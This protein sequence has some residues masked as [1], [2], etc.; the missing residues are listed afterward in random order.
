M[1]D[2]AG[3]STIRPNPY[4]GPRAFQFGETMYGRDQEIAELLDVLIAKRIVLLYSPSGAGKSSLIE[5]GLRAELTARDFRVFPTIRVGAEPPDELNGRDVRNRY[6]LSTIL[7]L[8][9]GRP[10]DRQRPFAEL[11]SVDLDSYLEDLCRDEE[12]VS[13]PCFVFDQFEELFT[14]DPTDIDAKRAFVTELGVALRNPGRWVLFAMR[15]D[16]IAQLDPY[17]QRVPNR[18]ATR[19]RLDLLEPTAAKLAARRPAADLGVAFSEDAADRLVSD[20]RRV[21][22]QRGAVAGYEPGPYVEP[23]QLQVVCRQLWSRL[24]PAA[25]A[26][27]VDDVVALGNVDDALANFYVDEVVA[28]AARTG[29]SEREIRTWFDQSLISP[30][31]FRTQTLDGPGAAGEA[32]LRE[33]ENAHLIRADRRRGTEWYELSHDRLVAPVQTSNARWREEHLNPLQREA[34]TWDARS[35]PAGLLITGEVLTEAEQWAEAHEAELL[36]IDREYLEASR[37]EQRRLDLEH[38]VHR[39]NRALTAVAVVVSVLALAALVYTNNQ[40]ASANRARA[41]AVKA[42][43]DRDQL[44]ASSLWLAAG[45]QTADA[46]IQALAWLEAFEHNPGNQSPDMA[47]KLMTAQHYLA[48]DRLYAGTVRTIDPTGA[49]VAFAGDDGRVRVVDVAT[50]AEQPG[51]ALSDGQ[52]VDALAYGAIGEVLGVGRRGAV[53]LWEGDG[54]AGELTSPGL[55]EHSSIAGLSIAGGAGGLVAAVAVDESSADGSGRLLVWDAGKAIDPPDGTSSGVTRAVVAGNRLAVLVTDP[56]D[57]AAGILQVWQRTPTGWLEQPLVPPGAQPPAV[58]LGGALAL[59]ADGRFVAAGTVSGLQVYPTF[60]PAAAPPSQPADDPDRR[61]ANVIGASFLTAGGDAVRAV[62]TS[63]RVYDWRLQPDKSWEGTPRATLP[64]SGDVQMD[65][66]GGRAVAGSGDTFTVA[67]TVTGDRLLGQFAASAGSISGGRAVVLQRSGAVD[68]QASPQAPWTRGTPSGA[69]GLAL[70]PD[71][72]RRALL[73]ASGSS[74]QVSANGGTTIDQPLCAELSG[75]E[76]AAAPSDAGGIAVAIADNGAVVAS[77]DRPGA[78]TWC[79]ALPGRSPFPGFSLQDE[80]YH[81]VGISA[82][83]SHFAVGTELG[84]GGTADLYDADGKLLALWPLPSPVT[85]VT[86]AA[87][88]AG[89]PQVVAGDAQGNIVAFQPE[90]TADF[91]V[92][93]RCSAAL[94]TTE[95]VVAMSATAG[96]FGALL[97]A[98][99]TRRGVYV[100]EVAAGGDSCHLMGGFDVMRD[101]G[102]V[103]ALSLDERGQVTTL[104]SDFNVYSFDPLAPPAKVAEVVSGLWDAHGTS[105]Y[106]N[107]DALPKTARC[108]RP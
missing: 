80:R 88:E 106:L 18:L 36:P 32:V 76:G 85:A 69:V 16:F 89:Q 64:P 6:V 54:K 30:D 40:R 63:G 51:P 2:P 26:I 68:D 108:P 10:R 34:Q 9:E 21:R 86:F 24:A 65:G 57:A 12:S 105:R 3:A 8:E 92:T 81:A 78:S 42:L 1:T 103:L 38:K 37:A 27:T 43:A 23:V 19:Y 53:S 45:A 74:V 4:V 39:R 60:D 13:D 73:S 33:L 62:D 47:R 107:C 11:A 67:D 95:P 79:L 97:I 48:H 52:P 29:V 87:G 84:G 5:A 15:E 82:D 55:G 25:S 7:S 61:A 90:P 77:A 22:V 98:A 46:R 99:A 91:A 101:E 50:L 44:N 28:V 20:L 83:G 31:G 100:Y 35:R 41:T 56:G 75:G 58:R 72:Q 71:G 94:P 49:H 104:E 14:L 96:P 17:L 59:T 93:E 102:D 66:D 70:S